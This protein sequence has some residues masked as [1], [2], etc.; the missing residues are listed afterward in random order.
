MN[1]EMLNGLY[2]DESEETELNGFSR[3][4]PDG[5]QMNGFTRVNYK[6]DGYQLNGLVL[7][8]FMLNGIAEMTDDEFEQ[9]MDVL[10]NN[11]MQ[12]I[13][14]A[15]G[16]LTSLFSWVKERVKK[17]RQQIGEDARRTGRGLRGLIERFKERRRQKMEERVRSMQERLKGQLGAREKIQQMAAQFAQT[18][19]A[20]DMTPSEFGT[21]KGL[22][23]SRPWYKKP[24]KK[25]PMP[26]K[27]AVI[28]GG[29]LVAF[30]IA[31]RTGLIKTKKRR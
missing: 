14:A 19:P 3:V 30:M 24:F 17:R 1:I 4:S 21:E 15:I 22:F 29:A 12:G 11:D 26:A 27:I 23:D 18:P 31:K 13:G 9:V 8:D 2:P 16:G 10:E 6:M 5:D 25:W 20:G 7:N 28:G